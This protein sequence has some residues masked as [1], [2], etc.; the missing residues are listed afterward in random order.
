MAVD[1]NRP[2]NKCSCRWCDCKTNES[3]AICG[4]GCCDGSDCQKTE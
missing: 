1:T 3:I 2:S 4:C